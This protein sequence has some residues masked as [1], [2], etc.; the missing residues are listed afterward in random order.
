MV[1]WLLRVARLNFCP[2]SHKLL[3]PDI[4]LLLVGCILHLRSVEHNISLVA[5]S[6]DLSPFEKPNA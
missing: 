2:Y 1:I 6:A 5:M 4:D 3:C